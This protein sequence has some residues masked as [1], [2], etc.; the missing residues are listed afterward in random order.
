MQSK[1]LFNTHPV[2]DLPNGVGC[3]HCTILA[4]YNDTLEDL[5]TLFASFND[6]DMDLNIV[7]RSKCRMIL[8]HLLQ[9]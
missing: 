5:N 8:P 9:F 4:P 3:V 7:T 2:R 6:P 1:G